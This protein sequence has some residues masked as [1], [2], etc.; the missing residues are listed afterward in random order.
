MIQSLVDILES[1]K[2]LEKARQKYFWAGL[3]SYVE[4][5]VKRC[6]VCARVK[7]SS[8]TRGT[9]MQLTGAGYPME[10]KATDVIEKYSDSAILL[11]YIKQ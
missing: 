8:R 10:R 9:Q 1:E 11:T 6:D 4:Q 7:H 2:T 3:Y 5:Y